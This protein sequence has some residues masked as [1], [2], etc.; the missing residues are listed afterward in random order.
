MENA[1]ATT[2][3]EQMGGN[4]F[5]VMTGAR[6][7]L[8]SDNALSFRLPG[9]GGFTRGGI[10]FV[11]VTLEPDDT[12]TMEFGRV[13]GTKYTKINEYRDVYNAD[14]RRVFTSETGLETHL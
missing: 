9:G 5:V 13:Y 6:N 10:N 11:R 4:R 12:Y 2:I 7:M 8:A 1:V 3:L 14:L